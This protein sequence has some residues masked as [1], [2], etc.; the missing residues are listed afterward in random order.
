MAGHPVGPAQPDAERPRESGMGLRGCNRRLGVRAFDLR[1][2]HVGP[3]MSP[4]RVEEYDTA[5]GVVLI[6]DAVSLL[7][8]TW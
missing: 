6:R 4:G 7:I 8:L 1:E 2:P 5:R 3:V